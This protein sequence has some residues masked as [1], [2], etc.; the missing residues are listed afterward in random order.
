MPPSNSLAFE[1][2][3]CYFL[4]KSAT[5]T[6]QNLVRFGVSIDA[7]LLEKF[8]K[9]LDRGGYG[10][11]SEAFRDLIRARLVEERIQ[12]PDEEAM[13]VLTLVY[14]HH[15]RDLEEKLT[16]VQHHAH[17]HIITTTH[18]HLD[19]DNCMEVI[20]LRGKVGVV[21]SLATALAS[22]KG[23]KHSNLSVTSPRE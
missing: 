1:R 21:R 19:H 2:L 9:F 13:G 11:R 5:M 12:N 6:Q 23:V 7:D 10:T 4:T 18:V 3:Q 14:N 22:F 15:Q 17:H 8:D 16:D 20:L